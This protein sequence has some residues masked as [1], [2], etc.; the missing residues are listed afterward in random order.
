MR[1][2]LMDDIAGHD[3]P[4]HRVLRSAARLF[5]SAASLTWRRWNIPMWIV[6][7]WLF[8]IPLSTIGF[9]SM[10]FWAYGVDG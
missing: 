10:L 4:D 9:F 2:A 6:L 3:L 1:E 7:L 8:G 5:D